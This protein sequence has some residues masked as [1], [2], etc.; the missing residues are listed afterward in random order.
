MLLRRA[1]IVAIGTELLTGVR[2]ETLGEQVA[3]ELSTLSIET[4]SAPSYAMR[5]R[6]STRRSS[7]PSRAQT[8]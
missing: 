5:W 6:R 3:R 7:T 4:V 2:H 1:A 8:S